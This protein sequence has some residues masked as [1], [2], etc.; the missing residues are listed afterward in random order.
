MELVEEKIVDRKTAVAGLKSADVDKLIVDAFHMEAKMRP[1][2]ADNFRTIMTWVDEFRVM[3]VRANIDTPE[4][5][6]LAL[7]MGADG[8][9]LCRSEHMLSLIHI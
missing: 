8:I 6:G 2:V 4:D 1:E 5:A 7:Q 9:G 3:G